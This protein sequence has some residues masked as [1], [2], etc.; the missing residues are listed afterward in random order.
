M[1]LCRFTLTPLGSWASRLASDTLYGLVCW[2]VAE[3]E[4]EAACREI[5]AAF[6]ENDPP[7]LLSSAMP[8]DYLPMP[9]LP[10]PGRQKFR[11]LAASRGD[12]TEKALFEIL[13]KFKKFRKQ[14]WLPISIWLKHR[15]DLS[16]ENLFL[17]ESFCAE[18]KNVFSQIA[19]EPHVAIDRNT[20]TARDGQLFF[21]R[22]R[23]FSPAA[24]L[25]L[26][27]RT[28]MQQKLLDYLRL[29]G[30]QGFG[31]NASTGN[32]RFAIELDASFNP[33]N[34]ELQQANAQMICSVC[35][36]PELTN[37]K[38]YYKLEVKRGKTGPG[39]SNPF[40]KPF[41]MLQEGTVLF[42]L[43]Q[44]PF[45]LR[46]LNANSNVIQILAPLALPCRLK[47]LERKDE[48]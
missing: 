16:L 35:S 7:F 45:A 25:H 43:P 46:N 37:L 8:A 22:L 27:A 24:R 10:A 38:G 2:L 19:F 9:A 18:D 17:S 34:L 11:E 41:L 4:G 39:S 29:I 23:Y 47:N 1:K 6:L 15:D 40:K 13:C 32:G 42:T 5:T 28:S 12:Q 31:K 44:G 3:M 20:G 33:E 30:E 14:P 36:A 48:S 21:T 26:Y